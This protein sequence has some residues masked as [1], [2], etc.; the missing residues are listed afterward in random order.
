MAN[1][2][3]KVYL[4]SPTCPSVAKKGYEGVLQTWAHIISEDLPIEIISLTKSPTQISQGQFDVMSTSLKIYR[5]FINILYAFFTNKSF[6]ANLFYSKEIFQLL[7]DIDNQNKDILFI[8]FTIRSDCMSGAI[9]KNR[10][11]IHAVDS[12]SLNFQG[13]SHTEKNI[14]KKILYYIEYRRIAR[15]EKKMLADY[16]KSIFVSQRD[17]EFL[18]LD[19]AVEI[20]LAV[21]NHTRRN[22]NNNDN[23]FTIGMSGNFN[24]SPNINAAKFLIEKILPFLPTNTYVQ[25]IGYNADQFLEYCNKHKNLKTLDGVPDI[26]LALAALDVSIAPMQDGSGMQN[27]IL[28]AMALGV[29]V[30]TNDFGIGSIPACHG[31]SVIIYKDENDLI[32][33][34][35]KLSLEPT[36]RNEIG[37]NGFQ[38][39]ETNY[40]DSAVRKLIASDVY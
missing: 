25:L 9:K 36:L 11:I 39:V 3:K 32:S 10:K 28:D 24:Y 40:T 29:P 5:M 12:M 8:F 17:I 20:P 35:K 2:P 1:K 26:S 13:K 23:N 15:Y 33:W 7:N 6:Q 22:N 38:L 18:N 27:K 30:I 4:I 19:S 34:I 16:E 31:K 37:Q 21:K 14:F